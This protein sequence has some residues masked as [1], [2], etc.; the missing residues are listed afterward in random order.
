MTRRKLYAW[1]FYSNQK[2]TW[3]GVQVQRG[4]ELA[5]LAHDYRV[6]NG[7]YPDSL[8]E[9]VRSGQV[10][11]E[12]FEALRF[13]ESP[14]APRLSWTYEKPAL[15]HA[16]GITSPSPIIPWRGS[17]GRSIRINPDGSGEVSAANKFPPTASGI[18]K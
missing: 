13:Q 12:K 1:L 10:S 14:M 7:A 5:M 4:R 11:A 16:F 9:L 8:H 15:R 2:A 17:S 3:S 6:K 18:S